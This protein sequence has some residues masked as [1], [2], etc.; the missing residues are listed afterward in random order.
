MK[1]HHRF[2]GPHA[3]GGE[4]HNSDESGWWFERL[5]RFAPKFAGIALFVLSAF[6]DVRLALAAQTRQPTTLRTVKLGA[7]RLAGR[8]LYIGVE[9]EPADH[10]TI[11]FYDEKTGRT[12]TL[13]HISGQEYQTTDSPPVKFVLALPTSQIMEKAFVVENVADRLGASLWY[14]PEAGRRSTIVLIH[15][16]DDETRQMGF[17]IPYFVSHGLNVVSYDQRG[18]GESSGNW[19][20]TGPDSKADD[21]IAVI[22]KIKSDPAV[23]AHQIGVWGFSNGGWVAPMVATRFPLAFMILKSAPSETIV[24]NVLYEIGQA[25]RE[26]HRFTPSQVSDALGFECIILLALETNSNWSAAYE[27]LNAAKNQPWF[28]FMRIPP[29]M[30]TPPPQPM[31]SALRAALI[32]DPTATLQRVHTP[33]LALFGALD[34]NVDSVD[35]A[36]KFRKEFNRAGLKDLTILILPGAGHTLERSTTG[37]EDD[38]SMPERMVEGYP[39]AMIHWLNSRSHVGDIA[40]H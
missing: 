21:V 15:G 1:P 9:A 11:Q 3:L 32:Y 16:A 23:N 10:P 36:A 30:T 37:Y 39:G 6:P 34:K 18:T 13:K 38:P 22:Q 25:L 5:G 20:F 8:T 27:A 31:L 33:T 24:E 17:L 26:H 28:P 2:G 35:S 4:R 12:G 14:T 19:H 29:E 7:Y 40:A